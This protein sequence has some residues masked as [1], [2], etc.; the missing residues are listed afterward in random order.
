MGMSLPDGVES[1]SAV[2]I[3]GQMGE[4]YDE[5]LNDEAL[6][7]LA[8]LHRTFDER[9]RELLYARRQR[10]EEVAGGGSLGFLEETKEVREVDAQVAPPA[11]GLEH[12]RVEMTGPTDRKMT[13][14]ALTSG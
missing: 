3:R 13:I 7:F 5:I 14:N 10:Y 8:D 1:S 12:R 9:R 11:P 6:E 2:E 4:G